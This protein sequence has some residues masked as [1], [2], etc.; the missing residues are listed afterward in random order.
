MGIGERYHS[1]HR[2]TYRKLSKEHPRI[3]AELLLALA[4]KAINDT[5]G[6]E[7]M[8]AP[9]L[10]YRGLSLLR[11]YLGANMPRETLAERDIVA[12]KAR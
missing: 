3:N 4:P 7:G 2:N 11:S 9:A 8:V 6:P 5:L 10:V 1:P 12:Q